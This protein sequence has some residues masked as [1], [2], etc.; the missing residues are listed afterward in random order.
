MKKGIVLLVSLFFISVI[1]LLIFENL[2]KTDKLI[3]ESNLDYVNTQALISIN[4]YK[5]EI[6]KLL[7]KNKD[8]LDDIL[9]SDFFSSKIP[10]NAG[11]VKINV[12]LEKY[13]DMF[14]LNG[15]IQSD[16]NS[17]KKLEELFLNNGVDY[18]SFNYFINNYMSFLSKEDKGIKS[19]T[20]VWHLLDEYVKETNNDEIFKIKDKLGVITTTEESN[21]VFCRLDMDINNKLFSSQ[22]IYDVDKLVENKIEVRDFEFNFR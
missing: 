17:K 18:G 14:D 22:F 21:M 10:L 20:Q 19:T 11:N 9:D 13:E 12:T 2:D 15:F 16:E 7:L 6:G 8:S 5:N 4:N 1:S 3:K